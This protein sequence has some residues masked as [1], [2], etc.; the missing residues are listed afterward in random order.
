MKSDT[1]VTYHIFRSAYA[2]E[3]GNKALPC[4]ID[5]WVDGRLEEKE[6]RM[7]TALGDHIRPFELNPEHVTMKDDEIKS[8]YA[9]F[10]AD[11]RKK[12]VIK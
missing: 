11:L 9:D 10:L 3:N 2:S 5:D 4:H 12:G 1:K 6:R 8:D 7:R